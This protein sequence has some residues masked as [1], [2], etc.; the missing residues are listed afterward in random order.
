MDTPKVSIGHERTKQELD[1]LD[2]ISAARVRIIGLSCLFSRLANA[3]HDNEERDLFDG[4][5]FIMD[6]IESRIR[7]A[8]SYL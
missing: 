5:A 8:E 6:D 1:A 4:L 3:G 2:E 7:I